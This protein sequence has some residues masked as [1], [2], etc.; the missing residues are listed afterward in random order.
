[1]DFRDSPDEAAFRAE[2]RSWLADAL[3]A[4]WAEREP[5][6]GR[7][8]FEAAKEWTR[9]LFDAG[10]AGLTWPKEY[11]GAGLSLVEQVVL[12]EEL[13]KAGAPAGSEIRLRTPG[14]SRPK[15]IDALPCRVNQAS[16]RS[17]SSRS[18]SG[19]LASRRIERS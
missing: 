10:Y 8:D 15:K 2:L 16:A 5:H 1:M 4:D 12:T 17:K 14:I 6:V 3:P 9:R 13:A 19:S 7:W 11:G 18:T